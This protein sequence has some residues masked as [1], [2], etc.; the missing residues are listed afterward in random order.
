MRGLFHLV[1]CDRAVTQRTISC[2]VNIF[3]ILLGV[4]G[5]SHPKI[6]KLVDRKNCPLGSQPS[7]LQSYRHLECVCVCLLGLTVASSSTQS[8]GKGVRGHQVGRI[9]S[10]SWPSRIR[11]FSTNQLVAFLLKAVVM[12][13]L[14]KAAHNREINLTSHCT[15]SKLPLQKCIRSNTYR[16]DPLMFPTKSLCTF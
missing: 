13:M 2:W 10:N 4:L 3:Y 5:K 15:W 11:F 14:M 6:R 8:S 7:T 16:S 9:S 1:E 12:K